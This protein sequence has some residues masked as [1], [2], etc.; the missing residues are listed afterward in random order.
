MIYEPGGYEFGL[1]QR[2]RMN[3]EQM[4]DSETRRPMMESSDVVPVGNQ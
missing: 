1:R 2:S 4:R 3:P